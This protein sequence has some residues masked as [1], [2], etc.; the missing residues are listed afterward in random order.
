MLS[1]DM[2]EYITE[3]KEITAKKVLIFINDAPSFVLYKNEP[4]KLGLIV[5]NIIEEEKINEIFNNILYNRALNRSLGLIRARDYTTFEIRTKLNSE[6]YPEAIV[7]LVIDEL[8]DKNFLDDKRFAYNYAAVYSSSRSSLMIKK[9]LL[10]KGIGNSI[11]DEVIQKL[12]QDDPEAENNVIKGLLAAKFD[13]YITFTDEK[14][15]YKYK[16]KA[17]AYLV[18][19]GFLFDKAD[20]AVK[21][22][23]DI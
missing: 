2:E 11:T 23:F 1:D 8:V 21:N 9:N 12:N 15:K 18:R 16:S 3:I 5:G 17:L 4:E 14:E 19:K 6:Y 20:S 10:K 22:F 7:S 13:P